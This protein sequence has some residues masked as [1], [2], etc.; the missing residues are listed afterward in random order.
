MQQ[1]TSINHYKVQGTRYKVQA[2]IR[3]SDKT[4]AI[5]YDIARGLFV[6]LMNRRIE[7][8]YIV[9]NNISRIP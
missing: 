1:S 4:R 5:E 2:F 7:Q 3:Y 6:N 8:L 9:S